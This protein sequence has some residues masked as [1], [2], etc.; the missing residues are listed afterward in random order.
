MARHAGQPQLAGK[1]FYRT[2]IIFC[3][4]LTVLSLAGCGGSGGGGTIAPTPTPT[5]TPVP[6]PT[7]APTPLPTGAIE[8]KVLDSTV[9]PGGIYQY[10]L[11]T[12]EPKPIGHGSTRPQVPPAFAARST[13]VARGTAI[14]D[15]NGLAAGIAVINSSGIAVQMV[16]AP[17][18]ST[19]GT[20]IAY[21]L[22][23]ISMQVPSTATPGSTSNASFDVANSSFFDASQTLYTLVPPTGPGVLTIGAVGTPYVSDVVPGGGLLPDRTLIKIFGGGFTT[24][25]RVA[26][27]D[28]NVLPVDT[29][30]VSSSEVDV[31]I[32][33]GPPLAATVTTCPNT[34]ATLQLDGERVRVRDNS[35]T[36]NALIDYYTYLRADDVPGSSVNT[37]VTQVH[38]MYARTT[39]T[40]A[41]IPLVKTATQFT[42]LS[43]QNTAGSDATIKIELLNSSN[44]SLTP[45]A[46]FSFILPGLTGTATAGKRITR[47]VIADWFG[48]TVP[49]GAAKVRMTVAPGPAVQALGMLGDTGTG[50]VTPVIPQ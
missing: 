28:T 20:N 3:W 40:T 26:I 19:L 11:S 14:N 6:T 5:P 24:S 12:T 8:F 47:D 36:P 27:E 37:L 2:V 25:T 4:I 17:T 35:F 41:T 38:P 7:P 18:G 42:G 46:T 48:G 31:R 33:N 22:L 16:G 44:G 21:P 10:Q 50:V 1:T 49:T 34:G 23:T 39:Y 29:T 43:V 45:P 32:C 9:P 13:V 30:F 15:P